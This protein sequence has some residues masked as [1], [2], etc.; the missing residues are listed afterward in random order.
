MRK[1]ASWWTEVWFSRIDPL[2]LGVFRIS[3]GLL[4]LL[5]LIALGPNWERFYGP[6]GILSLSRPD[7][8]S[9][10]GGWSAFVWTGRHLPVQVYWWMGLVAAAA[11][12]VGWQTRLATVLLYLLQASMVHRAPLVVNG[13]D[14]VFRMLLFYG[15]FAP[16][17]AALSVDGWL[18]TRRLGQAASVS[19]SPHPLVWPVRLMQVNIAL[20]YLISLPTK[21]CDPSG[22][23]LR[24]DAIYWSMMNDMWSQWPW[25]W[26]FYDGHLLLS[27]LMTYGTILVEGTFPLLVWFRKTRP[28]VLVGI[29]ALH[30]GIAAM[31]PNVTF[32]TLAMVCSFW[33]FVPAESLRRFVRSVK[34]ITT[35]MA[36]RFRL[37]HS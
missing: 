5:M 7:S 18:R 21:V 9:L 8:V 15:C 23:W 3:L 6:D 34:T 16:L 35:Q 12:V 10:Q 4:F 28:Y 26:M 29:T 33:L 32:F 14:L 1:L 37:S 36:G 30:L 27:R 25:K 11:F 31:I 20:I 17:G 19:E 13:E 22:E 2:P 24:G